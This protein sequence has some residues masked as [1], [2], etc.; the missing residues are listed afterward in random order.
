[1]QVKAGTQFLKLDKA[2]NIWGIKS[3]F[4]PLSGGSDSMKIKR[5]K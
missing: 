3:S 4:A 2:W 5:Y 1:M